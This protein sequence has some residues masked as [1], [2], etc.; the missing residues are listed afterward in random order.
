MEELV[1]LLATILSQLQAGTCNHD[2]RLVVIDSLSA[3]VATA[4]AAANAASGSSTKSQHQHAL[5]TDL[6][7]YMK[8]LAKQHFVGVVYTNNTK[9]AASVRRVTD[10]KNLV[11][12]PLAWA[13]DK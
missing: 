8:A 7:Y 2:L 11:T 10:L 12:E 1:V 4:T 5:I 9:E 13:A 6:L 3:L